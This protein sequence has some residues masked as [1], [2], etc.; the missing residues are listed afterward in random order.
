MKENVLFVR[1][2]KIE[3]NVIVCLLFLKAVDI[4]TSVKSF[5]QLFEYLKLLFMT[6]NYNL[7]KMGLVIFLLIVI[8]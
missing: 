4:Y 2:R 3:N 7:K 8:F 1:S 6:T 5:L